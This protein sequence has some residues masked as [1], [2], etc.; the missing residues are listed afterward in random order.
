[1]EENECDIHSCEAFIYLCIYVHV[2]VDE[3]GGQRSVSFLMP[4]SSLRQG[5]R[6][7]VELND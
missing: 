7:N 6:R 1:M 5:L 2:C 3:C 4:F